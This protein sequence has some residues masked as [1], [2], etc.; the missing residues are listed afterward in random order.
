MFYVSAGFFFCFHSMRGEPMAG[1]ISFGDGLLIGSRADGLWRGPGARR[2]IESGGG[3]PGCLN[4]GKRFRGE[5]SVQ[6]VE[7]IELYNWDS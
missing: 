1:M 6:M 4:S 7:I 5:P 2:T 3:S